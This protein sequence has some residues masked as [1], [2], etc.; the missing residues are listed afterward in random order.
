MTVTMHVF[1]GYRDALEAFLSQNIGRFYVYELCRPN[2]EVFYVG[3]GMNRRV[4]EHE[5]EAIRHHPIG[6]S[7]PFKCNVIRQV[8][9]DRHRIK[10]RIDRL[11]EAA[12]E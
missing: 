9:N 12:D 2:G 5:L 11:Y 8:L 6:E 3:K 10:Y 1:E 7:N 4:I